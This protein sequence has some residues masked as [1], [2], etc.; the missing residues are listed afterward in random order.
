MNKSELELRSLVD[1]AFI[2]Q[3][4]E[5]VIHN[6]EFPIGDFKRCKA[7]KHSAHCEEVLLYSRLAFDR[8]LTFKEALQTLDTIFETYHK[9]AQASSVNITK[10]VIYVS[11]LLQ[12]L[13]RHKECSELFIRL[14]NILPK[15]HVSK[16]L[17]FEQAAYEFLMLKQYRKFAFYMQKAALH[18]EMA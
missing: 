13:R 17:F 18:F 5:T 14:A 6:A 12:E 11:E 9:K 10:F 2:I 7:F 4:Y 1:T 8:T 3:D 15:D 16:P